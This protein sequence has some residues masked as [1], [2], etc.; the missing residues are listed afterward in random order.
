MTR[1]SGIEVVTEILLS[2][3]VIHTHRPAAKAAANAD[4]LPGERTSVISGRLYATVSIHAIIDPLMVQQWRRIAW[5]AALPEQASEHACQ[6]YGRIFD[7]DR[8]GAEEFRWLYAAIYQRCKLCCGSAR[9]FFVDSYAFGASVRWP[10][11][12]VHLLHE[13]PHPSHFDP[14]FMG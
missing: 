7:T 14:Y 8:G 10:R 4:L 3:Y 5:D 6:Q 1:D 12:I 11:R 13:S 2:D 9:D